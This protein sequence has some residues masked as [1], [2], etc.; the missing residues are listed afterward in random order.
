MTTAH[1]F[2]ETCR[3]GGEGK[4]SRRGDGKPAASMPHGVRACFAVPVLLARQRTTSKL[5][6]LYEHHALLWLR[7]LLLLA[8]LQ[9]Q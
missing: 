4:E 9:K 1:S 6:H 7:P 3:F 5:D 8:G 2:S